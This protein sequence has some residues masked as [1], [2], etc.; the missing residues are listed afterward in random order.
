MAQIYLT[1]FEFYSHNKLQLWY[2]NGT[3]SVIELNQ[4]SGKIVWT[5]KNFIKHTGIVL[6]I[7]LSSGREFYIHN[8]PSPGKAT[9]VDT[10]NFARGNDIYYEKEECINTPNEVIA[11]GL[12]AVI[13]GVKYKLI[14]QN[15]QHFTSQACENKNKSEGIDTLV[16]LGLSIFA[17]SAI[18]VAV[19]AAS[20]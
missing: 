19:A 8:H 11:I 1:S 13:K 4:D 10:Y 20:K 18:G 17:V 7:C 9:V 16:A 3:Y 6:G 15:C 2:S 12:N 14:T 5:R